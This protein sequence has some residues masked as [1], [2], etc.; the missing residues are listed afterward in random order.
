MPRKKPKSAADRLDANEIGYRTVQAALGNIPKPIPPDE[1]TEKSPEAMKRGRKGGKKGGRA[2][3]DLLT[4]DELVK[5]AKQGARA[6]WAK[7][8]TE[9]PATD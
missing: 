4:P 7:T 3:A 2:R 8:P 1:R 9:K 6:R 5:I